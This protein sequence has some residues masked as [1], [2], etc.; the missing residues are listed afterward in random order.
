LCSAGEADQ[1]AAKVKPRVERG[2]ATWYGSK[3]YGRKMASGEP[4]DRQ[5]LTAAHRKLPFGTVVEVTDKRSGC[6]VYVTLR[7]SCWCDLDLC[8]VPEAVHRAA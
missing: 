6:K 8:A 1:A 3:L 2:L 5:K 4:M 7:T